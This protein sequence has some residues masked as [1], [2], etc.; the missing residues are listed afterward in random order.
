MMKYIDVLDSQLKSVALLKNGC[1]GSELGYANNMRLLLIANPHSFEITHKCTSQASKAPCW[2]LAAGLDFIA[3]HNGRQIQLGTQPLA[4][5]FDTSEYV[6]S[7]DG[8]RDLT[9]A[10]LKSRNFRPRPGDFKLIKMQEIDFELS[11]DVQQITAHQIHPNKT[12]CISTIC[13]GIRN[14]F[15]RW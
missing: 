6:M 9:P 8:I 7:A 1:I 14:F 12:S 2:H 13:D 15:G 4:T 10:Y 5:V 11:E 3:F